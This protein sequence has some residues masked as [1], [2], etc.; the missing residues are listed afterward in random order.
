MKK[1][2]TII[3]LFLLASCKPSVDINNEFSY[4]FD[5]DLN[6][7]E[8][9]LETP[10]WDGI[11]S[12]GDY[13]DLANT[14]HDLYHDPYEVVMDSPLCEREEI[15]G[16]DESKSNLSRDYLESFFEYQYP[17]ECLEAYRI[18]YDMDDY[19]S[20]FDD[21]LASNLPMDEFIDNSGHYGYSFYKVHLVDDS[22]YMDSYGMFDEEVTHRI[23]MYATVV[24]D[25]TYIDITRV[26]YHEGAP[27]TYERQ[28]NHEN[29]FHLRMNSSEID[30]N[31]QGYYSFFISFVNG[32]SYSLGN[33]YG[34][35]SESF[36]V[37]E[38]GVVLSL[39]HGEDGNYSWGL[40]FERDG[41]EYLNVG[42]NQ[43]AKRVSIILDLIALDNWTKIKVEEAYFTPFNSTKKLD[44]TPFTGVFLTYSN[45]TPTIF[46]RYD[47]ED[48]DTLTNEMFQTINESF[49]ENIS[50]EAIYELR[51]ESF[52]GIQQVRALFGLD[53][54][55]EDLEQ[56]LR[57]Q[58]LNGIPDAYVFDES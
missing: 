13:E 17:I 4:D 40:N 14:M 33:Y 7:M 50:V 34:D 56:I 16:V 58:V 31:N 53:V 37:R 29:H 9:Q 1:L 20:F 38:S 27:Y 44:I 32:D 47:N 25:N 39:N 35:I 30:T 26:H 36:E 6:S 42:E 12:T 43:T 3:L 52:I 41:K 2:L 45:G 11:T 24:N 49:G 15:E 55:S 57:D 22:I 8:Y 5:F 21:Q 46:M 48:T 23:V 51:D 54:N 19:A 18:L 10:N 28:I